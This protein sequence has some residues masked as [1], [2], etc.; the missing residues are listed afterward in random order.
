MN[1]LSY[2]GVFLCLISFF[3][4][5]FA[6]VCFVLKERFTANHLAFSWVACYL[7]LY[8]G[9]MMVNASLGFKPH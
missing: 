1:W 9:L 2:I 4:C 3:G 7:V 8:C 6:G 5:I